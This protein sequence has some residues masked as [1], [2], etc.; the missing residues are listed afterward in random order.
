MKFEFDQNLL[1]E[2]LT[3]LIN[4][5]PAKSNILSITNLLAEIE[6]DKIIFRATDLK[7]TM[8]LPLPNEFPEPTKFMVNAKKFGNLIRAMKSGLVTFMLDNDVLVIK[9][10]DIRFKMRVNLDVNDFPR[11]PVV[12]ED[13]VVDINPDK[14]LRSINKIN[15]VTDSELIES[16]EQVIALSLNNDTFSSSGNDGLLYGVYNHIIDDIEYPELHLVINTNSLNNTAKLLQNYIRDKMKLTI[17]TKFI[18]INY[19]EYTVYLK[20]SE[21]KPINLSHLLQYK[22]TQTI[23][24]NR[25]EFLSSFSILS[26]VLD[27]QGQAYIMLNIE[28]EKITLKVQSEEMSEGTYV[29]PC[30]NSGD[31]L[32]LAFYFNY[33]P[34]ILH[35]IDGENILIRYKSN[36]EG[37]KVLCAIE[38]EK[39]EDKEYYIYILAIL[40]DVIYEEVDE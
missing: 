28:K 29:L 15:F 32:K 38:A 21:K 26:N 22:T 40:L 35:H 33:L 20:L 34:K 30:E 5:V 18:K 1:V 19:G 3:P 37:N 36:E 2:R 31:D 12:E 14:F 17:G 23:K 9:Q 39:Y 10:D 13:N 27:K 16:Q 4:I 25:Q 7:T 8:V 11:M 6:K 24:I